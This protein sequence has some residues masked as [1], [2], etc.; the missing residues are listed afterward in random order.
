M[1]SY[2]YIQKLGTSICKYFKLNMDVQKSYV[3]TIVPT[4]RSKTPRLVL[5]ASNL[6][7]PIRV[8]PL[9]MG[10][11]DGASIGKLGITSFYTS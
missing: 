5:N 8:R 1:D 2:S 4:H 9:L 10:Y 6:E 11:F 3:P 7:H